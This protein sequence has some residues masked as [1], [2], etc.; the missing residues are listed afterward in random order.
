MDE[1]KNQH[2][3]QPIDPHRELDQRDLTQNPVLVGIR[4]QTLAVGG[5][6]DANSASTDSSPQFFHELLRRFEL[7]MPGRRAV[8]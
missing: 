3:I 2:R 6:A 1:A 7:G 4:R 8:K 5:N